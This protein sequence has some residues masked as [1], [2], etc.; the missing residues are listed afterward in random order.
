[1]WVGSQPQVAFVPEAF[2]QEAKGFFCFVFVFCPPPQTLEG[3]RSLLHGDSRM[4]HVSMGQASLHQFRL[5]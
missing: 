3:A 1:M 5:S 2:S 4:I